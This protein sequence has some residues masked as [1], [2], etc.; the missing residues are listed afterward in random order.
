MTECAF[1]QTKR[2]KGKKVPESL[3]YEHSTCGDE[4][5]ADVSLLLNARF[6]GSFAPGQRVSVDYAVH[7]V[8]GLAAT[9]PD[10]DSLRQVAD[11]LDQAFASYVSQS[12]TPQRPQVRQLTLSPNPSTG[13]F[14]IRGS[15]SPLVSVQVYSTLGQLV[16]TTPV[17]GNLIDLSHLRPGSYFVLGRDEQH[18]LYRSQLMI[19]R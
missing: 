13:L 4:R 11:A 16:L 14:A 12:S 2:T 1:N 19:A 8:E 7:V 9:C 5:A 3:G 6:P 15:T 10:R 17:T 18:Q